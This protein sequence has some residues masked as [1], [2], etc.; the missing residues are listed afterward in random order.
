MFLCRDRICTTRRHHHLLHPVFRFAKVYRPGRAAIHAMVG[1]HGKSVME[2]LARETGGAYF[3]ISENNTLENAYAQIEDTLRNQY[4]IRYAPQ[5]TSRSGEYH[6]IK[7][8]AK[9]PVLT[10]QTREGY[11]SR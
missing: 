8:T 1:N 10:V 4:S 2:R 6:K 9:K 3:E 11:Y 5:S 7:L